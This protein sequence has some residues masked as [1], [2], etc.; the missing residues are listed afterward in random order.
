MHFNKISDPV[1]SVWF[2]VKM[3]R[4]LYVPLKISFFLNLKAKD[5]TLGKC[6]KPTNIS[7]FAKY[8]Y[9]TLSLCAK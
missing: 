7:L 2:I 6:P 4:I 5:K 8:I 1:L 9:S 3:R